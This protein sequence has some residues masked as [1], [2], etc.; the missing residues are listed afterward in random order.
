VNL[1]CALAAAAFVVAVPAAQSA[2]RVGGFYMAAPEGWHP[3]TAEGMVANLQV[4]IDPAQMRQIVTNLSASTVLAVYQKYLPAQ[5]RGLIPKVQVTLRRSP[6]KTFDGFR[7]AVARSAEQL[8]KVFPDVTFIQPLHEVSVGGRRGVSFTATYSLDT[9]TA[10]TLQVRALTYA[11]P[12]DDTFFQFSMTDGSG[13]DCVAIF[14]ELMR[15][16]RF[17]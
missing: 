15:T 5:H 16:V 10:G 3:V 13:E 8:R 14:A 4:Q 2:S 6:A 9:K 11:I 7:M 12:N 1:L 17:E